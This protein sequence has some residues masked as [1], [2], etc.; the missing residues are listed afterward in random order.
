M[1]NACALVNLNA[2]LPVMGALLGVILG[3][4]VG[5]VVHWTE[6]KNE[7][8]SVLQALLWEMEDAKPLLGLPT[9]ILRAPTPSFET[10]LSRGLLSLL[11][12]AVAARVLAARSMLQV[13]QR[14]LEDFMVDIQRSGP[15]QRK[16]DVETLTGLAKATLPVLAAAIE[17]V[18][19][20]LGRHAVS[21]KFPIEVLPPTISA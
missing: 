5:Y 10:L 1:H 2:W 21:R 14:N 15:Q 7:L 19:N 3:G 8:R 20:Y 4:I 13:H 17:A 18:R 11:P 9:A 16:A 6:R 12:H